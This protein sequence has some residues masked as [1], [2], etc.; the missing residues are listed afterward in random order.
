MFTVRKYIYEMAMILAMYV[1]IYTILS[2]SGSSEKLMN[3]AIQY[4]ANEWKPSLFNV[5]LVKFIFYPLY[6]LDISFIHLPT[7]DCE[8]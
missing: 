6:I 2:I 1:F 3:S 7:C 4:H 5:K 8:L